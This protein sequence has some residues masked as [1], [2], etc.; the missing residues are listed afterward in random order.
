MTSYKYDNMDEIGHQTY[1]YYTHAQNRDPK[2]GTLTHQPTHPQNT[3]ISIWLALN[4]VFFCNIL[5]QWRGRAVTTPM[6]IWGLTIGR[7]R[8]WWKTKTIKEA[9]TF[10][11]QYKR[12]NTTGESYYKNHSFGWTAVLHDIPTYIL[13]LVN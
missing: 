6:G 13:D 8:R 2:H 11:N 5:I 12:Q 9:M 7:N 10:A 4:L 1:R 3:K